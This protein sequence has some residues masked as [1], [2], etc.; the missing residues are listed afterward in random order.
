M[1]WKNLALYECKHP[2]H[3][4]ISF[5]FLNTKK[6]KHNLKEL[7][8]I[9]IE[10]KALSTFQFS[11]KYVWFS[12]AYICRLGPFIRSNERDFGHVR[13]RGLLPSRSWCSSSSSTCCEDD[14]SQMSL[15]HGGTA[16][17][18]SDPNGCHLQWR[19]CKGNISSRRWGIQS[20][21]INYIWTLT[22]SKNLFYKIVDFRVKVGMKCSIY[23]IFQEN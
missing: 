5:F 1:G 3:E 10:R 23:L 19:V 13:L 11:Q 7:Q 15:R 9:R 8:K 6:Q 2:I 14:C 16:S 21:I 17:G 4:V 18:N 20:I 12:G 22:R